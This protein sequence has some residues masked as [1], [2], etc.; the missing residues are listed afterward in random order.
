MKKITHKDIILKR[1]EKYGEVN[2]LWAI[3]SGIWRLGATIYN[4]RQDGYEIQ[5]DYLKKPDGTST[6]IFNYIL[7]K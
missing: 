2:N 3:N 1:L 5:G 4:L 6:K 7:I